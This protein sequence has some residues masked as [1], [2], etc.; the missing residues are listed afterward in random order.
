MALPGS[1]LMPPPKRR[2]GETER[3]PL[4]WLGQRQQEPPHF[5]G[6]EGNQLGGWSPFLPP[7][8]QTR[9]TSR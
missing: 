2:P 4:G 1:G 5:R 6:G 9:V 8:A 7:V 3:E